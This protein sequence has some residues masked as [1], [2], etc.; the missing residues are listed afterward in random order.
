MTHPD[1]EIAFFND[2]AFKIAPTAAQ[3]GAY[4]QRLRLERPPEPQT[5][6]RALLPSGYVRAAVGAAYLLC[7]CAP[8]GPDEQPGHAH[9]DSLT[10]ELSLAGH[11]L[12]VNSGTSR[13]GI[14]PERQ[15]QR[16]TAAHNTVE[17][18]GS[19][20]SEV[21]AGF[22][23]ARRAQSRLLQAL[24]TA[25]G[26][27][28]EGYHDGYRRL[29]GRNVHTRRWQLDA[30]SLRIEDG[31]TGRFGRG[32]ANFHLHPDI[33][34]QT[35]GPREVSL[36]GIPGWSV[37]MLFENAASVEVI[38]STWHPEFGLTVPNRCVVVC[39]TADILKTGIT[40]TQVS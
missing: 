6:L 12:C 36:R 14:G 22:R 11:R 29:P 16:G 32:V 19:N 26:V 8:V 20:S 7:D 5:P 24:S 4:A 30:H 40:W 18:D 10:F 13:Y 27:L 15:R 39:F 31:I 37:R 28:I 3:L 23:V 35:V 1:G 17:L 34:A 33:V 9:A 2:A 21:W 25:H 38:P